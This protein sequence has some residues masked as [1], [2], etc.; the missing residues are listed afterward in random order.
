MILKVKS[1]IGLRE[2]NSEIKAE[3]TI[4]HSQA[5]AHAHAH[6]AAEGNEQTKQT[7]NFAAAAFE[8]IVRHIFYQSVANS[9]NLPLVT[10]T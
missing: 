10:H 2:S 8:W 3:Q 6:R 1:N 5:H 9:S 7:E 4:K